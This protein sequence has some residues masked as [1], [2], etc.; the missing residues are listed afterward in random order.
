MVTSA[1]E[2]PVRQVWRSADTSGVRVSPRAVGPW[3]AIVTLTA[4]GAAAAAG[5]A[6]TAPKHYKATAQL[7]VTPVPA[8]DPTYLGLDLLRSDSKQS[9][10]ASAA[11]LVRSPQVADAVRAQLGLDRS[12]DSLLDSVDA[13]VVDGSDVVAITVD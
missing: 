12:R 3:L 1:C 11:A 5:Y 7:L 9:A 6:A 8:N 10:A 2:G 13:D 4:A